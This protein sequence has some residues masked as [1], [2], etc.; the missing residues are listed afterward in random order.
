MNAAA[1]LGD[2]IE[3]LK[4]RGF[5]DKNNKEEFL[6]FEGK[7]V[8]ECG[9]FT[10]SYQ[11]Q[12]GSTSWAGS[13]SIVV[14]MNDITHMK[15]Y[16]DNLNTHKDQL[17]ATV[18]HEL[19]TPLNGMLAMLELSIDE[20]KGQN[21][22]IIEKLDVVRNSGKLLLHMINDILDMSLLGKGRLRLN[23]ESFDIRA[24]IEDCFKLLNLQSSSKGVKLVL[25]DNY[26]KGQQIKTDGNRLRQVLIN[27][28][29]NAIKFTF[30]G[31]ITV[32]IS[33]YRGAGSNEDSSSKSERRNLLNEQIE[34]NLKK[35]D[36]SSISKTNV[37]QGILIEVV[38]TGIG[39]KAENLNSLF[40]LFGSLPQ[41]NENINKH[42]IGLG[43][44]ISQSLVINLNA[45]RPDWEIKVK[46]Q[47]GKG[48]NFY[49]PLLFVSDE[50]PP[51]HQEIDVK[52][53]FQQPLKLSSRQSFTEGKNKRES[54][55][56]NL[57][58]KESEASFIQT[59]IKKP[60][61]VKI[62]VVDD[63]QINLL[64]AKSFLQASP[65]FDFLVSSAINGSE[66]VDQ[67]LHHQEAGEPFDVIL[68]DC[69]MPIMDGFEAVK[70]IRE[71]VLAG[72]LSNL[73]IIAVTANVGLA[74]RE[75]CL[76]VGF[77]D[78]LSKPYSR[79]ELIEVVGRRIL[80]KS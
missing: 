79:K 16:Y 4:K 19:R 45:H 47:I 12:L 36:N 11:I 5:D 51:S 59:Y 64:V 56:E 53:S 74:D 23:F 69:N 34:I 21:S 24:L 3:A 38:D 67:V 58:S 76:K 68:M 29:G 52:K 63:D 32:R 26:R 25:E 61:R 28:I 77:H 75:K 10:K 66:A 20:I 54:I 8:S 35:I 13:A 44:A 70:V 1:S 72:R 39:I 55:Y 65:E 17:L 48:S 57:E 41:S 14:I 27:L 18:S 40:K 9:A 80:K 22:A 49:F 73:N 30:K 37:S 15:N 50:I 31:S 7:I 42:G 71:R 78:F 6:N 43:L 60:E 46:S 2:L 33:E 62:L